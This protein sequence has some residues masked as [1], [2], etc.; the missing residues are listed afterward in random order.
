[1]E[2]GIFNIDTQFLSMIAAIAS[3]LATWFTYSYNKNKD[4]NINEADFLYSVVQLAALYTKIQALYF[5]YDRSTKERISEVRELNRDC[6]FNECDKAFYNYS[7]PEKFIEKFTNLVTLISFWKGT[8]PKTSKEL[9][10]DFCNAQDVLI[11]CY[12]ILNEVYKNGGYGREKVLCVVEDTLFRGRDEN[13]I[14]KDLKKL[15]KDYKKFSV[16]NDYIVVIF[17]GVFNSCK[18]NG[19][20]LNKEKVKDKIIM[21][22][23]KD[24][25]E[26]K[27]DLDAFVGDRRKIEEYLKIDDDILA[28]NIYRDVIECLSMRYAAVDLIRK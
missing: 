15:E 26:G 1:M 25:V 17:D 24:V 28:T 7:F 23:I 8:T 16:G 11:Q 22:Y 21:T 6:I 9:L 19:S 18:R 4:K 13:S 5:D 2:L 14:D 27:M 20:E 3:A 12:E 10:A